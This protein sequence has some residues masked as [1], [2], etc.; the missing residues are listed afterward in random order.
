[1]IFY[2]KV[3]KVVY[4]K[5]CWVNPTFYLHQEDYFSTEINIWMSRVCLFMAIHPFLGLKA[6]QKGQIHMNNKQNP[7]STCCNA[8]KRSLM[9]NYLDLL[10]LLPFLSVSENTEFLAHYVIKWFPEL[11]LTKEEL[12]R[13]LIL[14]LTPC[15]PENAPSSLL[16]VCTHSC[17]CPS[18]A[19]SCC[20]FLAGV[21]NMLRKGT[22]L[23]R[24][25]TW[26]VSSEGVYWWVFRLYLQTILCIL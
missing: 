18:P 10:F 22:S 26:G 12:W 21:C 13:Q 11:R 4:V 19:T 7:I 15:A 8:C 24:F 17:S 5:H 16:D 25:T 14:T 20:S 6:A 2:L 1:M 9:T 3:S 23:C